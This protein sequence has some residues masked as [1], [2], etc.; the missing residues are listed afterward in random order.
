MDQVRQEVSDASALEAY[1]DRYRRLH[2]LPDDRRGIRM[3]VVNLQRRGFPKEEI[4]RVLQ[5][6]VPAATWLTL[7]TGE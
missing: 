7:D 3:L 1:L 2:P 5:K 6:K 4:Y